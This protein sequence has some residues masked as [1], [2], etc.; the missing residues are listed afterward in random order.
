[1]NE[2]PIKL[3]A[4]SFAMLAISGKCK[5]DKPDPVVIDTSPRAVVEFEEPEEAEIVAYG[6]KVHMEGKIIG[7]EK[8]AGYTL[9][10]KS[11]TDSLIYSFSDSSEA[12]TFNFHQHW[13][14]NLNR[15]YSVRVKAETTVKSSGKKISDEKLIIAQGK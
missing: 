12:D 6:D 5:K 13:E 10:I 3:I 4:L 8:L 1:M 9:T 7:K 11:P 2:L 14:N 15:T